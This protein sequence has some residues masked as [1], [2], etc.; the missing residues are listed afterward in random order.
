LK[1]RTFSP[2][3]H[4]TK[5]KTSAGV[6]D[7]QPRYFHE[8]AARHG[9]AKPAKDFGLYIFDSFKVF[10]GRRYVTLNNFPGK[11]NALAVLLDDLATFEILGHYN[12]PQSEE[13]SESAVNRLPDETWLAI[14]RNDGGDRN[15]HFTT[16]KNGVDWTV[17]EGMPV[18]QG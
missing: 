10:D 11:Q 2:T 18:L 1:T 3:I 7:M 8:D 6:F 15:Y 12:E 17:A 9:F 4:R 13:L 5:L 16:S 14:C